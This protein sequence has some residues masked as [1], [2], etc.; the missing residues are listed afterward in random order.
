M[1]GIDFR[2][3]NINNLMYADDTSLLALEEK[4]LQNP[5]VMVNDEGKPYGMAIN[6]KKT[7]QW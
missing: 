2:G 5:L 1:E 4:K 7:S 6:V 3:H